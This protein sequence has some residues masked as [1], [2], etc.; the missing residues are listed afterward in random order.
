VLDEF[1]GDVSALNDLGYLWAERGQHLHRALAMTHQAVAAEPKNR[2][3]RDSL[4]WAY[5]QL[6]RYAEAVRELRLAAA[7]DTADGVVLD[8]LGDAESR[9][10]R[11]DAA[12]AAWQRAAAAFEKA[13]ESGKTAVVK[14]KLDGE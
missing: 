9:Y 8:H 7:D 5:Y 1:P 3:Y 13:G 4:G 10:G 11:A 6:G 12:S 2:A 14:A